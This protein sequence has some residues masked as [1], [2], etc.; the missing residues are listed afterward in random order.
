MYHNLLI[1]FTIQDKINN[2]LNNLNKINSKKVLSKTY[3]K[4]FLTLRKN[5]LQKNK[6]LKLNKKVRIN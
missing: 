5:T 1:T 6:I 3:C 4:I 2:F